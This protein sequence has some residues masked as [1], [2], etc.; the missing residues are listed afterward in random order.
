MIRFPVHD[1]GLVLILCS[2]FRPIRGFRAPTTVNSLP[3][4]HGGPSPAVHQGQQPH[5]PVATTTFPSSKSALTLARSSSGGSGSEETD[6]QDDPTA[7]RRGSSGGLV[8]T[9]ISSLQS[10]LASA[11]SNLDE[12]DQYDAVLTGLC[13][14][15]LDDTSL[16]GDK[17]TAALRDPIQLLEEM[18]TRKV[19]AGSRSLMALIDVR[20]TYWRVLQPPINDK[21]TVIG[22]KRTMMICCVLLLW[23]KCRFLNQELFPLKSP[24]HVVGTPG[25]GGGST[26]TVGCGFGE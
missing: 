7:T 17:V 13:A 19:R 8:A 18:N 11:F 10:Q 22:V 15:I 24:I 26:A 25:L 20:T 9:G 4:T 14:K 5:A 12:R 2:F 16:S 3:I 6:A 23:T 1:L 21:F